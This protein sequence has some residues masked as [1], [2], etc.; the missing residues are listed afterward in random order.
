MNVP[1]TRISISSI[2]RSILTCVNRR[3]PG[4]LRILDSSVASATRA[5][6]GS[7]RT[8]EGQTGEH[9]W[10]SFPREQA[11]AIAPVLD[12]Q[13]PVTKFETKSSPR[14]AQKNDMPSTY[15]RLQA[16]PWA[17]LLNYRNFSTAT[18]APE[19]LAAAAPS[20]VYVH[21]HILS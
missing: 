17:P 3:W 1:T 10:D 6:C 9:D 16:K 8:H 19:P 18:L 14:S 2:L 15:S 4:Q 21:G 20:L 12:M 11:A 5:L 7:C 13:K